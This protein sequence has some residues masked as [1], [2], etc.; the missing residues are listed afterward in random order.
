MKKMIFVLFVLCAA[1]CGGKP[2]LNSTDTEYVHTTVD[3]LKARANFAVGEDSIHI[4]R[5]L[6]SVYRQHHT[7]ASQ[8]RTQ[9]VSLADDPKHAE[10]VFAAINDS[11][12]KK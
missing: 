7:S 11:I 8:Y 10:A 6:D 2:S 9:T 5:S 1:S 12:S 4:T 3:L